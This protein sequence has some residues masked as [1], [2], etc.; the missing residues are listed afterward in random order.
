VAPRRKQ[1]ELQAARG[2]VGGS[3][4]GVFE[5]TG[6]LEVRLCRVL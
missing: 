2:N 5:L 3:V 4:D 1:K 6:V